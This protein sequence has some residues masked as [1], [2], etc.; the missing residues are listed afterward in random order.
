MDPKDSIPAMTA[1][2]MPGLF[3]SDDKPESLGD[4][5][6]CGSENVKPSLLGGMPAIV[7][8]DCGLTLSGGDHGDEMLAEAWNHGREA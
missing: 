6:S 5:L 7:C 2:N 8:G 1:E 4:C 3:K